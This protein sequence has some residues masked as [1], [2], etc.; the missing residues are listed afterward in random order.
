MT[1]V[2]NLYGRY[3][4]MQGADE[5]RQYAVE[6]KAYYW[7]KYNAVSKYRHN[8]ALVL[9]ARRL[10]RLVHALLTMNEPCVRPQMASNS[11]EDQLRP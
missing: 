2:G 3:Y 9:T 4:F 6:Y 1:K 8:R 7:R 10:V 5:A 11:R